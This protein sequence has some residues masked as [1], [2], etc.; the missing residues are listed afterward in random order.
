MGLIGLLLSEQ[1]I[2]R[3]KMVT[4][5]LPAH[6]IGDALNAHWDDD[7]IPKRRSPG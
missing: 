5:K 1:K 7:S 2:G 4:V 3:G 6:L